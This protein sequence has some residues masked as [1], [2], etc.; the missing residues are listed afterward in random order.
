MARIPAG[1]FQMGDAFAE[2]VANE[3][4]VHKVCLTRD[5]F[6]DQHEVTNAAYKAC[7][8]AKACAEPGKAGSRTRPSYFGNAEFAAYPVTFV[9]WNQAKAYCGWAGKRLPSEAEWEYAARGT[10]AGK[11][12]PWGDSVSCAD[13]NYERGEGHPCRDEGGLPNDTHAVGSHAANGYGLYDMAGN[14]W[15]WVHD[16]YSETY[17]SESP[18]NDPPG[19]DPDYPVVRGGSW[20][21]SP[22]YLRVS[23]RGN[24]APTL[25]DDLIG[26]RCAH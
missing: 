26:F 19:A 11:R 14:V 1:C 22:T 9:N 17:Y 8:D 12:Y 25:Q 24:Y 21:G 3:L 16:G 23:Y 13:A 7:V 15:E 20:P 6:L 10:L 18:V 4:P 5:F 2:G